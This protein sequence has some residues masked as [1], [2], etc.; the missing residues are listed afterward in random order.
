[1]EDKDIIVIEGIE[2]KRVPDPCIGEVCEGCFVKRGHLC[3]KVPYDF[4][5]ILKKYILIPNEI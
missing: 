2:Y 1:M 5:F 4:C 3:C